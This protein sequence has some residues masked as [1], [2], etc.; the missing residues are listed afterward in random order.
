MFLPAQMPREQLFCLL[1]ALLA[2]GRQS[3]HVVGQQGYHVRMS[4]IEGSIRTPLYNETFN[5]S[6]YNFWNGTRIE[7]V[8]DF[9]NQRK[10]IHP[11]RSLLIIELKAIGSNKIEYGV[12]NGSLKTLNITK[13]DKGE[14]RSLEYPKGWAANVGSAGN[15]FSACDRKGNLICGTIVFHLNRV[16]CTEDQVKE[17]DL[18]DFSSANMNRKITF[19]YTF[20]QQTEG[21]NEETPGLILTW[22][23]KLDYEKQKKRADWPDRFLELSQLGKE[24][25]T[26]DFRDL[27]DKTKIDCG[28]Q[29]QQQNPET[30]FE[31]PNYRSYSVILHL[32]SEVVEKVKKAGKLVVEI[33]GDTRF[34]SQEGEIYAEEGIRDWAVFK[35][36]DVLWQEAEARCVGYGGHL[37]SVTRSNEIIAAERCWIG[38]KGTKAEQEQEKG[39]WKWSDGSALIFTN[40]E[41]SYKAR[42]IKSDQC[43]KTLSDG[44]WRKTD[45]ANSTEQCF[46]C[47]FKRRGQRTLTLRNGTERTLTLAY[48]GRT[49][50]EGKQNL[51]LEYRS[52]ELPLPLINITFV[53]NETRADKG[54]GKKRYLPGFRVTWKTSETSEESELDSGEWKP[55]LF[56]PNHR[57]VSFLLT[58]SLVREVLKSG[59]TWE[60]LR[61]NFFTKREEYIKHQIGCEEGFLPEPMYL[62]L[63]EHLRNNTNTSM[64]INDVYPSKGDQQKGLRVYLL[65]SQCSREAQKAHQF[66]NSHRD[67]PGTLLQGI[68]NTLLKNR[69]QE[70]FTRVHFRDFYS[71][72][73]RELELQH[74]RLLLALGSPAELEIITKKDLPFLDRYKTEVIACLHEVNV[75]LQILILRLV[76]FRETAQKP[77]P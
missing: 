76:T 33:V 63:L 4:G 7:Y 77:T 27:Y 29:R 23:T 41:T 61:D 69:F 58:S 13:I 31:L 40:W 2:K 39:Q 36:D 25:K 10:V 3:V 49:K 21:E 11:L 51:R 60:T 71:V 15:A 73:D 19:V 1:S 5:V 46:V 38:L 20:E 75:T 34:G 35:S 48:G 70:H 64:S 44:S 8:F 32:T 47:D 74:G 42:Q 18:R 16:L 43:V 62:G 65:L 14:K 67:R 22:R 68:V 55:H 6:Q 28:E 72:L 57:Q 9:K 37:A 26:P 24:V 56:H 52:T 12:S 66:I 30:K 53:F 50:L 17:C 45:C 54:K 59:A